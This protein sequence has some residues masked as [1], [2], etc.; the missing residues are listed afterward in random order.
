MNIDNN[1]K[2][3]ENRSRI[4]EIAIKSA[5]STVKDYADRNLSPENKL[6]DDSDNLSDEGDGVS[7]DSAEEKDD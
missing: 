4:H 3:I 2:L 1:I 7:E 5:H 6:K